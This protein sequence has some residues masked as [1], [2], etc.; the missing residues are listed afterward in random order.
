MLFDS[1]FA[2]ASPAGRNARLSILIFHRV[3][4]T[5]DPLFPEE[6]DMA[7][8]G[9]ILGW[10]GAWFRVLPLDD[11]VTRL[12]AGTLP[13]RAVAI[14]FD[15]GYADNFENALPLLE[16]HQLPA[17]FFVSTG[18]LD[19]GR[20][21]NDTV[22]EAIRACPDETLH[23]DDPGL[24]LGRFRL[25]SVEDKRR[26]IE[27]IIP[28]IKYLPVHERAENAERIARIAGVDLPSNLMMTS[29]QIRQLHRLGMQIGAHTMAHPN[30]VTIGLDE[31]RKE[32]A[33]SK[34]F[35]EE[36]LETRVRLFAYPNG[37]P[38]KDY[39]PEH[40]HL[41][42]EL[43][44]DAAFSTTHG[45]ATRHSDP[46]QLPRFTPWDRTQTRFALR[47]LRNMLFRYQ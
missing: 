29:E 2:L 11:A 40:V 4:R 13:A 36:R 21:W 39:S 6:P 3:F 19:G 22:I 16:K 42:R 32:I 41:A 44:F 33:G 8:F 23:L 18:F 7:R 31:A 20:M 14:S 9:E 27:T 35:L 38:G 12:Q 17:T 45:C 28:R 10:L 37:K 43:G 25:A 15:D 34:R 5:R 30:L 26:A 47:L 24:G 46:F 1:L